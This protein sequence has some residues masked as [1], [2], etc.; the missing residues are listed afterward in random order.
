MA[1]QPAL[2]RAVAHD[3]GTIYRPVRGPEDAPALLAVHL[4]RQ[5]CDAVDPLGRSEAFPT[6]AGL[7]AFLTATAQKGE[8]ECWRVAE[9]DGVVA[10]YGRIIEW[11]EADGMWVYLALGWVLPQW[12]GNGIGTALLRW[13]E[14]TADRLATADHPGEPYEYAAN[15]SSTEPDATALLLNEGFSAGYTILEMEHDR[16]FPLPEPALPPGLAMRPVEPDHL[17]PISES[18]HEAYRNE[19]AG[20][21]YREIF[22]PRQYAVELAGPGYDPT[23]W[24]VAWAGDEVAG[25][26]L[27]MI[28]KGYSEVFEVSVRPCWRRQG[29]ARALLLS[30]LR[31]LR[32]RNVEVIRL[33]TVAEF[34]T[35]AHDLYRSVG[36]R[37]LKEFPRYRK[38][39]AQ[40]AAEYRSRDQS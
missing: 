36:F 10:G 11:Q 37:V 7:T 19:Y 34:R 3:G 28:D 20:D 6:L 14:A 38:P 24:R 26:A 9:V 5:V 1:E 22:D 21:R 16:A 4:G 32:E 12:R 33:G 35:H 15:A 17:L 31:G 2:G 8:T 13:G 23:L 29:V 39:P 27:S 25:Q 30:A 40:R 18:I